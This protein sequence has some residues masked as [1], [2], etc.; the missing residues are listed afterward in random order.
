MKF[1]AFVLM[2]ALAAALTVS[3]CEGLFGEDNSTN[4]SANFQSR[5]HNMGRNC[6][7]CH[8]SGGEGEGWFTAAGTAYK[9]DGRTTSPNGK[10]ELWT[11]KD[12]TG[13]LVTTIQ[14]DA[15]GNFFTTESIDYGSGLYPKVISATGASKSMPSSITEGRCNNCHDTF[16]EARITTP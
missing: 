3:G 10:V 15:R 14:V 1:P 9:S 6:M 2:G 12:G 8:T 11:G 13:V 4:I 16:T 7:Q 5:S